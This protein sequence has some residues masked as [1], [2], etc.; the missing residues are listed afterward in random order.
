MPVPALAL[1]PPLATTSKSQSSQRASSSAPSSAISAATSLA[2]HNGFDITHELRYNTDQYTG[3]ETITLY[4]F[5]SYISASL[6]QLR[7]RFRD[8]R[9]SLSCVMSCC[10][11]Y[12]LM[13]LSDNRD[14][15]ALAEL[16]ERFDELRSVK[17]GYKMQLYAWFSSFPAVI[18]DT[19]S[20]GSNKRTFS[21]AE[22]V[23]SRLCDLATDL[24][25]S[26]SALV[27]LALLIALNR[28]DT[29]L[30]EHR[31][32]MGVSVEAFFGGTRIRCEV[33]LKILEMIQGM[34]KVAG[35]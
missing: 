22:S 20:V 34:G 5:P 1:L 17:A 4:A 28:Q 21:L 32:A 6:D 27:Q 13:V 29:T 15:L 16:K 12:G 33:G 19:V 9:P 10:C 23:R 14:V 25:M 7:T 8:P 31:S 18:Q 2:D 24:S 26:Y 11:Y 3:S 30:A 35:A